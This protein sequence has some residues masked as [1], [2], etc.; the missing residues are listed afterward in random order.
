[1]AQSS[2]IIEYLASRNR[3]DANRVN[4][5][6]TEHAGERAEERDFNIN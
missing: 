6:V 4:F 1:M 5:R 2:A 3:E